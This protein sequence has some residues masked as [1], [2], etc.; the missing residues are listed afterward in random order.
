MGHLRTNRM[1][2][3]GVC[4][5][6]LGFPWPWTRSKGEAP[7][8]TWL[9]CL[10]AGLR[11][12]LSP[13]L[14]SQLFLF[15]LRLTTCSIAWDPGSRPDSAPGSLVPTRIQKFIFPVPSRDLLCILDQFINYCRAPTLSQ[16]L[17][18]HSR[19]I[20]MTQV[21]QSSVYPRRTQILQNVGIKC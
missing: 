2:S 12:P 20:P 15:V 1:W 8:W 13:D 18:S 17:V 7:P 9:W 19:N 21:N 11:R 3:L 10:Q 5:H 16:A 4:Y 6:P 14:R